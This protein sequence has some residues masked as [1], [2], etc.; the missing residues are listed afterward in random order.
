MGQT[1]A[2]KTVTSV[3]WTYLSYVLSKSSAFITI[4]VLTYLI[5]PAEFGIVG[6]ATT[7]M[8]FLDAVRDLGVGLALIQRRKDIE[9]AAS[10]AFWLTLTSNLVI[11]SLAFITAPAVADFFREPDITV[12]LPILSIGFI[13]NGLGATHDALL[14]REMSFGKRAIPTVLASIVKSIVSITLALLGFGV[15]ALVLGQLSGQTTFTLI[16]WRIMPWRPRLMW[17]L[18]IIKELLQ[19]GYKVSIDSLISA[20]QANI[21][22]IFIGRFLGETPL[23]LY[24]VGFRVPELVI[25]N[26][27]V[28]VANVLFP[29]YS[30]IQNDREKLQKAVLS[31]LR[32]VSLITVPAGIGLALIS[33]IFVST[34]F[35]EE[36]ESAGPIMAALSL[37]GMFL[38][39][40]WNVGDIYKAI[41]RTDILWKTAIIEF[42]LLAPVLYV[43]AQ[44]SA[45]A[46][47]LGHVVIAF[48]VSLLR[49]VIAIHILDLSYRET[50]S[51][52]VSAII[53][54]IFMGLAVQ[55]ILMITTPINGVLALVSAVLVGAIVYSTA[56]WWLERELALRILR[57][58]RSRIPGQ[59]MA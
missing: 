17:D 45:L 31:A 26:F 38:A 8:A 9:R 15:W 28:V 23:G 50:F 25:I 42:A 54:T 55:G 32:Y 57:M 12:I 52:F 40:S 43:M 10:I 18:Q 37:Y 29:A 49:L 58:V 24:T 22:Y 36:W 5:T 44:D 34:V 4:M 14:Q 59:K 33:P 6:F 47:A 51:Q 27:C 7:T 56:M 48:I 11:W 35:A 30:S 13:I 16:A 20:L 19:Y 46:V 53:G 1:L 3:I 39:V 21:D 41:N 2:N